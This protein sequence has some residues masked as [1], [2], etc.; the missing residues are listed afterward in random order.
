GAINI[1][2][3]HCYA[4]HWQAEMSGHRQPLGHCFESCCK[5]S[6]V[7]L[8]KLEQLLEPLHSLMSGT[9]PQSR[10]FL[11]KVRRWNS[12]FASTSISYN[13]DNGTTAQGGSL[14]LFQVH[15]AV[16]HLQRLIKVP[17][18]RDATFSQIYLY[19]PLYTAQDR[20]TRAQKLDTVTILALMQMFQECSPLIQM[21]KTAKERIEEAE[22]RDTEYRIMLNPQIKLVIKTVADKRRE[23]LPTSNQLALILSDQY[24]QAGYQGIVLAKRDNSGPMSESL[25]IIIQ[26]HASFFPMHYLLL[27]SY[28]ELRLH[29]CWELRNPN[30][31][32]QEV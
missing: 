25:A 13:M 11:K 14:Q 3:I 31:Q 23:K 2:C 5:Y 20:V 12:L 17:T 28:H 10:N 22:E 1:V 21:Y 27:F 19:D 6:N 4:K 9:T 8:E 24:G 30:G 7:V 29:W 18:G 32:Q 26:Y 15:G 16:Y